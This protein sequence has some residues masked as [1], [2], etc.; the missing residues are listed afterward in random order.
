MRDLIGN[1]GPQQNFCVAI[2]KRITVKTPQ[3]QFCIHIYSYHEYVYIA[4]I[5]IQNCF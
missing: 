4:A 2:S 5:C 1:K 3:K